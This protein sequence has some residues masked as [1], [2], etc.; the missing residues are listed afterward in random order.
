MA[1]LP[2]VK[3][4]IPSNPDNWMLI[5]RSDYDADVYILWSDPDRIEMPP[6]EGPT[7]EHERLAAIGEVI[8]NLDPDDASL[9]TRGGKPIVGAIEAVLGYDIEARERDYVWNQRQ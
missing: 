7:D 5:N 2:T 1:R 9:W 4:A 8:D 6:V 3:V